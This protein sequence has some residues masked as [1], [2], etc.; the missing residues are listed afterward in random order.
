MP[1]QKTRKCVAKRVKQTATGKFVRKRAG[2]R[3]LNTTKNAKRKRRLGKD[4][5]VD[6][7]SRETMRLNLPY[8]L[9]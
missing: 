4:A 5:A 8:G 3:H 1:K 7:A 6:V 9:R 2:V